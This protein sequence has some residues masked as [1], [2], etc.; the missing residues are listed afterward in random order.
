MKCWNAVFCFLC[1][2]FCNESHCLNSLSPM[3]FEIGGWEA[4]NGDTEIGTRED[5]SR[6]MK[7]Q[8]EWEFLKDDDDLNR[9]P[10]NFHHY[11]GTLIFFWRNSFFSWCLF[12]FFLSSSLSLFLFFFFMEK[13][14]CFFFLKQIFV[15]YQLSLAMRSS[16]LSLWFVLGMRWDGWGNFT[17][18][19]MLRGDLT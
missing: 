4:T 9:F 19:F 10:N 14:A 17:F 13:W 7:R 1:F 16:F 8:M 11:Q 2:F 3:I 6:K 15:K 5:V 18:V 12:L